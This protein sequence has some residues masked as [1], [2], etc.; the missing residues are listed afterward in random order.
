MSTVSLTINNTC[1]TENFDQG[2]S[3][4]M[5][6]A[7]KMMDLMTIQSLAIIA[8]IKVGYDGCDPADATS[9]V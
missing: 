7:T 1:P 4:L 9:S 6:I 3:I 2:V 5:I 8:F